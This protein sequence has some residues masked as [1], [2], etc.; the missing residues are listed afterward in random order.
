[1]PTQSEPKHPDDL[2]HERFEFVQQLQAWLEWPMII[3]G[4]AWLVLLVLEFVHGDNPVL[5]ILSA[6][7]WAIFIA[8]FVLKFFLAPH[9][10][11]FLLSNW[12]TAVS[13]VIPA[14]RVL[15]ATRVLLLARAGRGFRLVR[16]L[17]S[18]NRGMRALRSAMSRRGF[19]YIMT[20]STVIVFV[21]AAGMY[22]FEREQS[23]GFQSY[24]DAL[25]WTT[26]IVVTMGSGYWPQSGEGK[27]LCLGLS[28]YG[29]G[30]LGYVTAS[31]ASF[32][33]GRD[34]ETEG[35]EIASA[36]LLRTLRDEIVA[37]RQEVGT[38]KKS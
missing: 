23:G 24:A 26:M 30:I 12:L 32:F 37:L 38:L 28:L 3:L 8:D 6:T 22:A 14:L 21:S 35:G 33:I 36:A 17:G 11:E 15:R 1:M 18:M 31:L 20:L 29:F 5:S 10:R 34:A 27:L 19:G 2:E 9:K 13:L 25:W 7:I 16:V 4:F